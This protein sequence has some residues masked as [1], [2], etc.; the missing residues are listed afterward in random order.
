MKYAALAVSFA[1][2]FCGSFAARAKDLEDRDWI[3]VRTPHFE[4]QSAMGEQKTMELARHLQ[5]VRFVTSSLTNVESFDS[6]VPMRIFAFKNPRDMEELGV[7]GR[8]SGF[9][10]P[11]LR[12]D[13]IVIRDAYFDWELSA[14]LQQYVQYLLRNQ[15]TRLYPLWFDLGLAQ[16]L[17][18]ARI[19]GATA[20]IG[21]I[22][23]Q[24]ISRL[25]GGWIPLAKI[26]DHAAYEDWDGRPPVKFYGESWVLV[27]FLK[28][29]PGREDTLG[30]DMATYVELTG[31]GTG[32][33]AAFEQAFGVPSDTLDS[34]V[35]LYLQ[36]ADLLP[37][38]YS[39]TLP[40][41]TLETDV[42]LKDFHA[43][44]VAL[45][46]GQASLNLGDLALNLGQLEAAERLYDIAVTDRSV[47]AR[48]EAG[49]GDVLQFQGKFDDALLHLQHAIDLDPDDPDCLL[50][51]AEYWHNRARVADDEERR[52]EY[53]GRANRYYLEASKLDDSRPETYAQ[54]ALALIDQETDFDTA[55]DL[56][57]HARAL[58][59]SNDSVKLSL[60]QA[61]VRTER[62]EDAARLARSVLEW[63]RSGS[64]VAGAAQKILDELP[65]ETAR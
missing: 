58:A 47:E 20:S 42:V 45:T 61:Y 35:R 55:L 54:Y 40:H 64:S 12:R 13:I 19:L 27:H 62:Y 39:W 7:G 10:L 14:L 32:E 46:R 22:P 52:A 53:F 38:Y 60:A 23:D 44:T 17:E 49:L 50:S 48:A 15:D 21:A 11:G 51:Y 9:F 26:I 8:T 33:L 29:R 3:L 56:L 59:P 1:L 63:S 24:E 34:A 65:A 36:R 28:N 37:Q 43:E 4:I 30:R 31:Q 6:P 57:E 16:Y 25:P 2:F 18:S 41:Y 5:L